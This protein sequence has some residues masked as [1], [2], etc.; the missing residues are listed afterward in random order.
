MQIPDITMSVY[1]K[2]TLNNSSMI[3]HRGCPQ[4]EELHAQD[5]KVSMNDI[6]PKIHTEI[7]TQ[8]NTFQKGYFE[9]TLAWWKSKL[10]ISQIT[11]SLVKIR[12]FC[13]VNYN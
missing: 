13:T 2:N 10:K 3:H 9:I 6:L 11:C 4:G 12:H 7:I 5:V 1:Y 8:Q